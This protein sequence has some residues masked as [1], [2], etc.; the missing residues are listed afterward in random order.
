MFIATPTPR[1]EVSLD[2]IKIHLWS[3]QRVKSLHMGRGLG[4]VALKP[5]ANCHSIVGLCLNVWTWDMLRLSIMLQ[6]LSICVTH[7]L[8]KMFS[9]EKMIPGLLCAYVCLWGWWLYG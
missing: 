9:F 3:K 6:D 5:Y 1:V 7:V 2:G 8:K 4:Q